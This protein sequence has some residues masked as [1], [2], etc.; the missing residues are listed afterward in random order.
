MCS[1]TSTAMHAVKSRWHRTE[2]AAPTLALDPG[3]APPRASPGRRPARSTVAPCSINRR[4]NRPFPQPRSS[5][6]RPSSGD[7]LATI[8]LSRESSAASI[9]LEPAADR[10]EPGRDDRFMPCDHD[11]LPTRVSSRCFQALTATETP[12]K[13]T[14][15]ETFK[16][17]AKPLLD[18][19]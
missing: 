11:A 5:T 10:V 7:K 18:D 3:P 9:G 19:I 6:R 2:A 12:G 15:H 17:I 13:C 4:E 16:A 8:A 1:K 14:E